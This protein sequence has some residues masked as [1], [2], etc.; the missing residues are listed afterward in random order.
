MVAQRTARRNQGGQGQG[1]STHHPFQARRRE[2]K[3]VLQRRKGD[4][5]D[6]DI[7]HH[8][9]L[10]SARH[11]EGKPLPGHRTQNHEPSLPGLTGKH[12]VTAYPAKPIPRISCA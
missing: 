8:H 4:A 5:H 3:L 10:S 2:M 7:E 9:D 1:I 6:H 12:T 11:S